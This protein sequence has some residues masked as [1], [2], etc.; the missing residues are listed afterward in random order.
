MKKSNMKSIFIA[1]LLLIVVSGGYAQQKTWTLQECVTYAL[2]N[3]ISVKQSELDLDQSEIN[4]SD[5]FGNFLPTLNASG[6]HSWNIGL[7]Q[8]ITTGILE[9]LTTQFTSLGL[10]SNVAI[11]R[12]LR[13]LNTFRR[14]NL[15]IIASQY[16]ID[17]M[18]DDISLS[19]ANAYLQ[20]LFNREQLKVLRG[21]N[22][23]TVENIAQ[24]QKLIEA[25]VIPS[26]DILELEATDATQKQQI[27]SA[28][29]NL[30]LS[31]ISLAQLL[32]L[33]DYRNFDVETID[34]NLINEEILN[35]DPSTIISRAKAEI[36]D[37][38]I[39][40]TN[41]ELAEYDVK[42]AKGALLPTLSGFYSYS[43][44]ASYSDQVVGA[45]LNSDDPSTIIGFVE[46][47]NQNVVTPNYSSIIG[48]PD[49]IFDQF[50]RN[51]GHN[52]GLQIS[53]PILNGFSAKNNISRNKVSL[54]RSKYQLEQANLDLEATVYQA[55]NDAKNAKQAFEAATKTRDAREKAFGYVSDRY[56]LGVINSF[57]FNQ[58]KIQF[59]NSQADVIRT[60]YDFIF[61]LK[62]LEFYFGIPIR[63]I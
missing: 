62:I 56:E 54:E 19:V 37:I 60:K 31:K 57:D 12:G 38:K 44:R 8:N 16:Q 2:E 53:I 35:E 24:T 41:L 43:T 27:V 22:Q 21:Q 61:K 14:S 3:N 55:Y 58:S 51:D 33:K 11:Y 6:N 13:N 50:S 59:E 15:A 63:Q 46:D 47:T 32:Q 52:F 18:K 42:V 28:Q 10:N 26:G 4:K 34:Y 40:E 25:G 20:I 23:L 1:C 17:K 30:F 5:A 39:A 9:N 7:N 48:G 49:P 45:E 36:N 29:N